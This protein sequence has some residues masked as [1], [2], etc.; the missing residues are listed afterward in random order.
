MADLNKYHTHSDNNSGNGR[1]NGYEY[2]GHEPA[3]EDDEIDVKQS[4]FMLWNHKW[5][6]V[7]VVLL[8]AI[9]AGIYASFQTPIYRSNGSLL[10]TASQ[11]SLGGGAG[12]E[13]SN[14][15]S[16]TYGVGQGSTIN[17]ELQ[18]L[19][20]RNLSREIADTLLDKRYMS[21]GEQFPILFEEYPDDSTLA[22]KSVVAARIQNGLELS[23]IGK[24]TDLIQITYESPSPVEAAYIVNITMA[25]YSNLSTSQNRTA[26]TAAVQFLEQERER[27]E[28]NLSEAEDQLRSFMNE[29]NLV[30]VGPQTE[31]LIESIAEMESRKQ[32]ATVQLVTVNSAIEQ[33]EERLNNIK[34]GL[35]TQYT[36]AIG[37][38]MERL[39][40][41]MA[42]LKIERMQIQSNYPDL[43]VN[44]SPDL[45]AINNDIALYQE[46][47]QE[48]TQ[49]LIENSENSVGYIA[50]AGVN[51]GENIGD[52]NQKL[53]ELNVQQQQL[54]SEIQTL[55]Q[56]LDEEEQFFQGLPDNM[57]TLARLQREMAINEELYVSVSQQFAEMSLW[58][59]TQFGSG[60]VID[61][62]FITA[63]PV[64][65]NMKLFILIGFVLGAM[66][67]I[68]YIFTKESFNITVDSVEKLKSL[69]V[70]L[71]A[72]VPDMKSY[73]KKEQGGKETI[74]IQDFE[75]STRLITAYDTISPIS[76]SFRRMESNIVHSNPDKE[77]KTLM[78][79]STTKGEG[80]TTI[81]SNLGVIM[82]ETEQKVILVETD[83]RRPN[84]HNLFGLSNSPGMMDVLFE[85]VPLEQAIR[86]TIIPNLQMLPAGYIPPN[87]GA[88]TK[89][90]AFLNIIK[91]LENKYDYVLLDTPPFGIITDASSVIKQTDGIIVA[92]KFNET[93]QV[94]LKHTIEGLNKIN[95]NVIGTVMTQFD[96]TKSNDY[97]YGSG[98]YKNVYE[99]YSSY[100]TEERN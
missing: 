67:S 96:Y 83:L 4:L 54:Q 79:T 90:G 65:P 77:I 19:K 89:S 92:A 13:L 17:N 47:I 20:S 36:E 80:K 24:E 35:A 28:I 72:V 44:E 46:R 66:L 57:I 41:Q 37:P 23:R 48:L 98:Y 68:G 27:I 40:Y 32:Q 50:G 7:G 76:E 99:D 43:Q 18:I 1:Y 11:G 45:T 87:P 82:A 22:S 81:I 93:S 15:L 95:A 71:M 58:Q 34:P 21:N 63:L 6:I 100:Q 14:I 91:E 97:S 26:A 62:A 39:Q 51:I 86:P 60:R 3:K 55:N 70:P 49:T 74:T 53:I 9:L 38:E 8:C 29:E 59:Q 16:S 75:I 73:I 31:A 25:N 61:R 64:K 94:Q 56:Q 30:Q 52:L 88:I 33:F 85:N 42:E 12:G 10:I 84:I 78:V 69:G 5:T 2:N